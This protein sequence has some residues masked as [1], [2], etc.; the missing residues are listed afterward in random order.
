MTIYSEKNSF[1]LLS[2][3][4]DPDG[5]TITVR[6]IDGA[7]ISS[8][9]HTVALTTGTA[10][11]MENGVVTYD[12]GGDTS[13]HPTGGQSAGNGS[14]TYTL[15][16]GQDESPVYTASLTLSGIAASSLSAEFGANTKAGAGGVPVA[17]AAI[18]NGD[19]QGYFE[20]T[21]GELGISSAGEGNVAGLY[22][23]TLDNGDIWNVDVIADM[24]HVKTSAQL[25]T[26]VNEAKSQISN[27]KV[28]IVI[29]D[30]SVVGAAGEVL[31]YLSVLGGG[32]LVDPNNG[33]SDA[34]YDDAAY[35][36]FTGGHLVIKA[37]TVGGADIRAQMA[38]Y[39]C[40]GVKL[41]GLNFS[42]HVETWKPQ[43]Y[44]YADNTSGNSSA[45][46]DY[47]N[48]GDCESVRALT[49]T[50]N[51]SHTT[52]GYVIV[53]DCTFGAPAGIAAGHFCQAIQARYSSVVLQGNDFDRVWLGVK[54]Q[55]LD[56]ARLV[57][58]L[59]RNYL[60]DC[61]QAVYHVESGTIRIEA[62]NNYFLEPMY[63]PDW[64]GAHCD[65]IQLGTGADVRNY[66]IYYSGNYLLMMNGSY[67]AGSRVAP[68]SGGTITHTTPRQTQGFFSNHQS[69]SSQVSGTIQNNFIVIS[70]YWA[71]AVDNGN[72]LN[73]RKNTVLRDFTS[74]PYTQ[75]GSEALFN[76][77][78]DCVNCSAEK[79]ITGNLVAQ[80][81]GVTLSDNYS[82][83]DSQ[84]Q[85]TNSY[86][87]CFQG[88][89]R[90]W[91]CRGA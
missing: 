90:L 65:G 36:D 79:N 73:V 13:G 4:S 50:T 72:G 75:N 84:S 11:V 91:A 5:D 8:W 69:S 24:Y 87:G 44:Y 34:S 71:I 49:I 83:L 3:A 46:A 63:A 42:T 54:L 32:A 58:N 2:G 77:V 81:G 45:Y 28:T 1:S 41:Q 74:Q 56:R 12:D 55:D 6:R 10:Q 70:A 89:F 9:P 61:V 86:N 37:E 20:I 7:V 88:S 29:R 18:T 51:G 17:G 25:N 26:A 59:F 82:A 47:L 66:S 52:R 33:A 57:N 30:G 40:D 39:G 15:W 38:L 43:G 78:A 31:N 48:R 27:R 68:Y 80:G 53:E 23:L 64:A 76:F 14:F 60:E 19:A 21:G 16:D 85:L 67:T 62:S 22:A 35:A